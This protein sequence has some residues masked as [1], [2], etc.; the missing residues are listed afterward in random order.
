[1]LVYKF[2]G[3]DRID[4][5]LDIIINERLFCASYGTLND[6]YE[7]QAVFDRSKIYEA[8]VHP[9]SLSIPGLKEFEDSIPANARA[10]FMKNF[11]ASVADYRPPHL[12]GVCSLSTAIDDVRMWS[13]YA[14]DHR[15]FAV[16]VDLPEE[17]PIY[18]V[19]YL[20]TLSPADGM[21]PFNPVAALTRKSL[22]WAYEKEL[23]VLFDKSYF[24]VQGRV[25]RLI[26][27]HRTSVDLLQLLIKICPPSIRVVRAEIDLKERVRVLVRD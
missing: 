8:V 23:R 12:P 5:L 14:S 27:G 7:G 11:M 24:P 4:Y 3:V 1:M 16:E 17:P 13:H 26:A 9:E 2:R 15:G 18:S 22:H 25:R 6:P 20:E 10:E 19:R 21:L